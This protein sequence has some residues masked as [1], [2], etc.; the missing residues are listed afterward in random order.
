MFY[1]HRTI[2][3][4]AY[5]D[6]TGNS[7]VFIVKSKGKILGLSLIPCN[8]ISRYGIRSKRDASP[9][10]DRKIDDKM[11]QQL[12]LLAVTCGNETE[13]LKELNIRANANNDSLAKQIIKTLHG[14]E[15]N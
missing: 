15:S 7:V 2:P 9:K 10:V 14:G 1:F 5:L 8:E 6:E 4:E 13:A 11:T 12:P 3:Q